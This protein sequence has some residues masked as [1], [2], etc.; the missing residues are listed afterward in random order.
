MNALDGH[1]AGEKPYRATMAAP[2]QPSREGLSDG[3]AFVRGLTHACE[4]YLQPRHPSLAPV[5]HEQPGSRV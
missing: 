4:G 2:T 5:V 3:D 1:A